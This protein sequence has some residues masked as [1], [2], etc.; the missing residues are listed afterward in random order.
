MRFDEI[1]AYVV[2]ALGALNLIVYI[3]HIS[4][5]KLPVSFWK[6]EP[7]RQRWGKGAGTALHFTAYV[8][9]PIVLGVIL[10]SS[11]KAQPAQSD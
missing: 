9:A 1:V 11:R 10:L 6:L 4:G 3:A 2:L 8:L 5:V 7:M